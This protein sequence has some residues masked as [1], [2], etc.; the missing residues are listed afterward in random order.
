MPP[1]AT[2]PGNNARSG[3]DALDVRASPRATVAE[4]AGGGGLFEGPLPPDQVDGRTRIGNDPKAVSL[5][6]R[7]YVREPCASV[8]SSHARFGEDPSFG[9][10][11]PLE[12]GSLAERRYRSLGGPFKLANSDVP[13]QAQTAGKG[14]ERPESAAGETPVRYI[15][16]PS[17]SGSDVSFHYTRLPHS[18]ELRCL[19]RGGNDS[20]RGAG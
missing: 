6:I 10:R 3:S 7:R 19:R 9:R 8:H 17:E 13:S 15:H 12:C 5:A 11:S 1:S 18:K 2:P 4:A 14:Y 20:R 16:G